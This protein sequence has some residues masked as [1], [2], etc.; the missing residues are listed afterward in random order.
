[1]EYG[2]IV[3]TAWA[4]GAT[5]A[6]TAPVVKSY[7]VKPDGFEISKKATTFHNISHETACQEGVPLRDVLC[8]FME[9]VIKTHW[10][11]HS[12]VVS[13]R[14]DPDQIETLKSRLPDSDP[15]P[16]PSPT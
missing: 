6:S 15:I 4:M 13:H 9:D 14:L 1:M 3:E 2:R 8:L 11:H 10:P 7:L 5:Y 16:R 12:R